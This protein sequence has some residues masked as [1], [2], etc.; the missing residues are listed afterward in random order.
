MKIIGFFFVGNFFVTF[1]DA[2][3]GIKKIEVVSRIFRTFE[4]SLEM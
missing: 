2:C 1:V 4:E 3:G